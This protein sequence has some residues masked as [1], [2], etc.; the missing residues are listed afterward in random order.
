MMLKITYNIGMYNPITE[1]LK[2]TE[3]LKTISTLK[4]T[5]VKT[6][7]IIEGT[8]RQGLDVSIATNYGYIGEDYFVKTGL[9]SGYSLKESQIYNVDPEEILEW[10]GMSYD[11]I[12]LKYKNLLNKATLTGDKSKKI[13]SALH[14][15]TDIGDAIFFEIN[16][17]T[18][19][20]VGVDIQP[21]TNI[22]SVVEELSNLYYVVVNKSLKISTDKYM[23]LS[24]DDLNSIPEGFCKLETSLLSTPKTYLSKIKNDSYL[25]QVDN[26]YSVTLNYPLYIDG[27]ISNMYLTKRNETV[28]IQPLKNEE[29]FFD[30]VD[31]GVIND[32]MNLDNVAVF[33]N[34]IVALYELSDTNELTPYLLFV[35]NGILPIEEDD[36]IDAQNLHRLD[37]LQGNEEFK[38][39]YIIKQY[40]VEVILSNGEV[41]DIF[42][43]EL[44]KH[45]EQNI[46]TF[47]KKIVINGN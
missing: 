38:K 1:H 22:V 8:V 30:K 21:P 17:K 16:N 40:R 12:P 24:Y 39:K 10:N 18:I 5:K 26:K 23:Y 15:F 11:D 32:V 37:I 9:T 14:V 25:L 47:N 31:L 3:V 28:L 41:Y 36:K 42:D 27:V 33:K 13:Y 44:Y 35:S 19:E 29:V 7:Y 45:L 4:T 43:T 20:I 2:A 6:G 46:S 34:N